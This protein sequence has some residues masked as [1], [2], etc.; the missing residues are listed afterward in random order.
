MVERAGAARQMLRGED[1]GKG[2][3]EWMRGRRLVERDS[4]TREVRGRAN[5][6]SS[7][8]GL[9]GVLYVFSA[10]RGLLWCRRRQRE[11]LGR[12]RSLSSLSSRWS[13]IRCHRLS[14]T[15]PKRRRRE[16]HC[17]A[18]SLLLCKHGGLHAAFCLCTA[19]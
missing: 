1:Q 7:S 11:G 10:R 6:G 12:A 15:G 3:G 5:L 8:C 18:S 19:I 17:S 9:H 14:G 16:A 2:C 13:W 4:L